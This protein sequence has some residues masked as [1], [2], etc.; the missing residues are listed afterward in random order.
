MSPSIRRSAWPR[1]RHRCPPPCQGAGSRRARPPLQAGP[2]RRTMHPRRTRIPLLPPH[3]PRPPMTPDDRLDPTG[4]AGAATSTA[5]PPAGG[6]GPWKLLLSAAL[7]LAL[8]GGAA[9]LWLNLRP[10]SRG[11]EQGALLY[12][13]G[14][15][16]LQVTVTAEGN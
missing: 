9:L 8:A 11:P 13:V 10:G 12:T 2:A 4:P 14:R 5:R 3:P 6:R 15:A 7:V 1:L 16:P